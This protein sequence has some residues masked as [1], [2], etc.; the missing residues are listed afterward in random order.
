MTRRSAPLARPALVLGIVLAVCGC[1]AATPS[2][3]SVVPSVSAAVPTTASSGAPT[4]SPR[5]TPAS[6]APSAVPS[7]LAPSTAEPSPT[8][9]ATPAP[10]PVADR[11][12]EAGSYGDVQVN[13][14]SGT[15]L[16]SGRVLFLGTYY[17]ANDEVM[18]FASIWDPA[19]GGWSAAPTLP[20]LRSRAAIVALHDGR[21]LVAAG[22]NSPKANI[23]AQSYSSTYVF[24]EGAGWAKVGLLH[25]ARTSPCASVLKDGRVLL[26]GGFYYVPE[27][28]AADPGMALAVARPGPGNA[29]PGLADVDP[30]PIGNAMA[31]AEVFD[32]ATGEWSMTGP[33]RYARA[34]CTATTLS[35]GRVLVAGSVT[36]DGVGLPDAAASTAEVYDPATGKFSLTSGMPEPSGKFSSLRDF[37]P[38]GLSGHG[39]GRLFALPDG[40]A[41]LVGDETSFKHEGSMTRNFR[42]SATGAWTEVGPTFA[43]Y[44]D[45]MGKPEVFTPNV[46]ILSTAA[47]TA[48]P[49]GRVVA[50]GGEAAGSGAPD[51]SYKEV[52]TTQAWSVAVPKWTALPALPATRTGAIAVTLADGSVIVAG[53]DTPQGEDGSTWLTSIVRLGFKG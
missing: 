19:T 25:T 7:S 8:A 40:G 33:M 10:T 18:P 32:P 50:A 37:W 43:D 16:G 1:G 45:P 4:G 5:A 26:M 42:R 51:W 47:L 3:E 36:G 21:V 39:P 23:D 6:P 53:G 52:A 28:G 41:L 46:R 17:D 49:D 38:Q 34:G 35:D 2:P 15:L 11:W 27:Y 20:K 30:M 31:T 44:G 48:L 14:L 12:V 13:E 24:S 22:L 29:W 9:P